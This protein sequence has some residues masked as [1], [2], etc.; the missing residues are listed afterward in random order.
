MVNGLRAALTMYQGR[1]RQL[2]ISVT[3]CTIIDRRV[4]RLIAMFYIFTSG[5]CGMGIATATIIFVTIVGRLGERVLG[6]FIM[7]LC[8]L[9]STIG[10]LV[11]TFGLDRASYNGRVNR[12]A[13]M[14]DIGGV[15]FPQYSF[16]FLVYILN[17]AIG[18]RGRVLLM[19]FFLIGSIV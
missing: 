2:R 6:F 11:M 4:V 13:L 10:R 15:V 14:L 8:G 9:V 7:G 5:S 19:R 3:R 16:I 17:L 12:V 1:Q 18:Q